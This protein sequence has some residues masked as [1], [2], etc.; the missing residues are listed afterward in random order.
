MFKDN[1]KELFTVYLINWLNRLIGADMV[2]IY[3]GPQSQLFRV[4]KS[5]L[6]SKIPSFE[7]MFS[8]EFK[9]A[10]KNKAIFPED[11]PEAF[12][13][14][15]E[16]VY[17]GILRPLGHLTDEVGNKIKDDD[18]S[19]I[20]TWNF[21]RTY[22]LANKLCINS[23]MDMLISDRI[24]LSN[25]VNVFDGLTSL[26][27]DLPKLSRGSNLRKYFI[28][29]LHYILEERHTEADLKKWPTEEIQKLMENAEIALDILKL[30]RNHPP[31]THV[32]DPRKLPLCNFHTHGKDE[33]CPDKLA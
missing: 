8:N 23:L 28:H 31:G 20:L 13:I 11:D 26:K 2:D 7:K 19:F 24:R 25:A 6:T 16:W 5:F 30:I 33:E 17:T 18:G 1:S 9:E 4:H 14:L 3:V 15:I 22:G 27:T 21:Y 32:Q 12:E 10:K 29:V